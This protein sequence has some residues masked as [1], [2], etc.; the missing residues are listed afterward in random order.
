MSIR[1]ALATTLAVLLTVA[2]PVTRAAD[3]SLK[4]VPTPDLSKLAPAR[5]DELRKARTSFDKAKDALTGDP[6]AETYVLLGAAYARNGLFEA[7]D[8]AL[9][10]AT[11]L[12]PTN[13]RWVY[14]RGV[15]AAMQKQNAAAKT[16]FERALALDQDYLPI[17]TALAS[18]Q[19][20]SGD[21]GSARTVLESYTVR[22]QSQAVPFA[23]LGDIALR[24][25][26]PADAV[27]Q[28]KHALTL[29]PEANRLNAQLADAYAAT[30]DT[31][32]AA[33]AR[34]KAGPDA[35]VLFDPVGRAMLGDTAAQ[36]PLDPKQQAIGEANSLASSGQYDAARKRLDSAL[37]AAPNDSMLLSLYARVESES[38]N[39][40]A[41]EAR[42]KQAIAADSKNP[43]AY[44]SQGLMLEMR[45]DD[46]GAQRAYEQAVRLAPA[47]PSAR[48]SLGV[49]FVRTGRLADAVAQFRAL[50]QADAKNGEGWTRLV[51]AEVAQ[52]QCTAALKEL[53]EALRKAPNDGYMLQLFVRTASTCPAASAD[54]KRMALD[55]GL[56]LYHITDVPPVTEAYALALAANGKW[57]D[58][59]KTQQG[60]MFI[61]L[62]ND[63]KQALAPYTQVLQQFQAHK[64]PDRPWPADSGIF[65]PRRPAPVPAAVASPAPQKK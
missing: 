7:A 35:P 48:I 46:A 6:L 55:Y 54:E 16:Y 23:M 43:T 41:A 51:A 22:H 8:I 30:G 56:K 63:G 27:E 1:I 57:D 38:G 50:V 18:L 44:L 20:D 24:Q 29:A 64:V 37:Q 9:T 49:L 25:K 36:A 39:F 58:A 4:A 45:N 21:L 62:R 47:L 3:A 11:L 61:V 60:V 28:F 33:E 5:A 15:L 31:K 40:A 12:A 2:A 32:S 26:R 42:A 34:A 52:G 14:L 19:I 13:G 53:S 17:R 65:N 59:I 10:D